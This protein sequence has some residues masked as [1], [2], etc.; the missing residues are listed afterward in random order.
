VFLYH[1][2]SEPVL[3]HIANG[4]YGTL[5]IDPKGGWGP[6]QNFVLVQSEFYTQP[7][8]LHI[9]NGM[10][11]TLIIDPKG[12]WG[13]GQNFVLVQSEFYTQPVPG[14]PDLLQADLNKM[15]HGTA[16]W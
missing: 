11:G 6:G 16:T 3:L 13:P 15:M 2:G 10:Y 5:I 9:A 1:C 12:G 14:H 7:V 4:M 8:L